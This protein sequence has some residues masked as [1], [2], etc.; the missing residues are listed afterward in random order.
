MFSYLKVIITWKGLP[1]SGRGRD[2]GEDFAENL[3]KWQE[4]LGLNRLSETTPGGQR[5]LENGEHGELTTW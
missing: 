1:N 3:R 2:G 5:G 4:P